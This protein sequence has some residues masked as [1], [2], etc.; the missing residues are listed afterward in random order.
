MVRSS[1]AI[2]STAGGRSRRCPQLPA[3]REER[4]QVSHGV[5][6]AGLGPGDGAL[7]EHVANGPG[8]EG[9]RL[10]VW[11]GVGRE[12]RARGGAQAPRV[13]CGRRL[14]GARRRASRR[15]PGAASRSG[16]AVVVGAVCV[17]AGTGGASDARAANRLVAAKQLP[18]TSSPR[19][20]RRR[21]RCGTRP[22]GQLGHG[23]HLAQGVRDPGAVLAYLV[24]GADHGGSTVFLRCVC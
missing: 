3:E 4:L 11:A 22:R 10:K 13:R 7:W 12:E 20:P 5:D 19:S 6:A 8:V 23:D 9:L 2:L 18:G 14:R 17:R 21:P 15:A 16:L 24:P 1:A